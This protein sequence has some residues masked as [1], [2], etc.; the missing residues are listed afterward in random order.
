[1]RS[2][3]TVI[4]VALAG[5]CGKGATS[6]GAASPTTTPAV[7]PAPAAPEPE[8]EVER[9]VRQI[10][11][12]ADQLCACADLACADAVMA[13]VVSMKEPPGKPTQE[14]MDRVVA[15]A[16]RMMAC[17]AELG[18]FRERDEEIALTTA[19]KL[20]YE[21]YPQ[22]AMRPGNAGRCP[23]FADLAVY[24]DDPPDANDPWGNPY[25]ITCGA[26]LPAGAYGIAVFSRGADGR[27]G[28]ADDQR[29]W[30]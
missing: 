15:S 5:G 3:T 7:E 27:E 28:T 6:G 26:D 8:D 4:V 1:M 24:F 21:G 16:E 30:E 18:G 14:Q 17:H 13:Q 9:V 11:V 2:I 10:A 25:V 12:V 19:R 23:T 29:S 20:A 22:W